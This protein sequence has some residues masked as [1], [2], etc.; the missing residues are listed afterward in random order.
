MQSYKL[1]RADKSGKRQ[2]CWTLLKLWYM[3]Y[4]SITTG[5][6]VLGSMRRLGKNSQYESTS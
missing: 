4:I 6:L 2:I 3:Y 5:C 1:G